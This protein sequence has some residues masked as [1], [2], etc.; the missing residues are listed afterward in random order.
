MVFQATPGRNFQNKFLQIKNNIFFST[1]E[2]E[3]LKFL[4]LSPINQTYKNQ[5]K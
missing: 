4:R 3:K 1:N 2:C 5:L